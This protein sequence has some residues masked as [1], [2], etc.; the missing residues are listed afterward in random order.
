[1][2]ASGRRLRQLDAPRVETRAV[3]LAAG[4]FEIGASSWTPTITVADTVCGLPV[5]DP[6]ASCCALGRRERPVLAGLAVDDSMRV[7]DDN[8]TPVYTNM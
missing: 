7:V 6:P 2:D 1:M 3:I 8:G 5:M 4:G